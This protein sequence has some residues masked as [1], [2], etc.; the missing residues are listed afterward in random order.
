MS[1]Q[2]LPAT[3]AR[4]LWVRMAEI[5]GHRWT[6]S[7]GD[8]PN[9]GA[10]LTW[11]KGLG[12]MRPQQLADGLRNCIAS[13]DPWPPTLPE[14]RAMCLDIPSLTFVR[15]EIRDAGDRS[16]FTRLVWEKVDSYTY[17]RSSIEQ[18]DRMIR[19]AYELARE[20]V[21]RGGQVPGQISG[22]I[23]APEV[24]EIK[25]ADPDAP[26]RAREALW[27]DTGKMAVAGPDA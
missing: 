11:A 24:P 17:R 10:A 13:A 2:T 27:G 8:N 5:Y 14:F 15:Q 12:G 7:Y 26:A 9:E 1:E 20:F 16:P 23:E 22:Q 4:T 18:T 3:A 19:D 6:S 25:M 21:M